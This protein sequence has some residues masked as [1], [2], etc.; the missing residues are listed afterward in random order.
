MIDLDTAAARNGQKIYIMRRPGS[1]IGIG[2]VGGHLTPVPGAARTAADFAMSL[3]LA[4]LPRRPLLQHTN[5]LRVQ[6]LFGPN[7]APIDG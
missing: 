5:G 3:G 2:V 1:R 7:T 6:L 4:C